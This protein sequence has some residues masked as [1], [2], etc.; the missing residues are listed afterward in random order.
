M[1]T[2]RGKNPLDR[3]LGAESN[4][5]RCITQDSELNTLHTLPRSPSC[6]VRATLKK[7][8]QH[9]FT[10]TLS[11]GPQQPQYSNTGLLS[12]YPPDHSSHNS[13]TLVYCHVFLRT[14]AATI[15]QHWVTVTLS[16]GPQQPQYSN[17]GLLTRYPPYHSSHPA[18]LV[19]C[20]VI[21]RTTAATMQQHWFTVTLSSGP[22]QP[23]SNTGLLSRY[24]PD[25]SSHPAT[26]VYCHVILRTTAATMQQHWFTVTL[27]SGPQQP[28]CSNTGLLSR[29]P[30]D[31]SSH[32]A[33]TLVYCHVYLQTTAATMQQHWFTV[34]FSS[35][36]QQPQRSFYFQRLLKKNVTQF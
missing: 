26:L 29:Y 10:V 4:T 3:R 13:A 2:P 34:T 35:G 12:R 1:L 17:T 32:N 31:H 18:T 6:V 5:G 23:P 16:S 15:Q 19:Y 25:H 11:S 33:A 8:Q 36:P 20:H 27:S 7:L 21:L 22:Q 24:P 28:Q 14:T 30:P 9:W